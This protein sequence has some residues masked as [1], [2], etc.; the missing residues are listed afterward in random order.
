MSRMPSLKIADSPRR[1]SSPAVRASVRAQ[2]VDAADE[3]QIL[4]LG[5]VYEELMHLLHRHGN[6]GFLNVICMPARVLTLLCARC[7]DVRKIDLTLLRNVPFWVRVIEEA[8]RISGASAIRVES[9]D[10]CRDTWVMR[11]STAAL[12]ELKRS[13]E[14]R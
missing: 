6:A 3:P 13:V 11:D 14:G 2:A 10:S 8:C 1:S 12:A 5:H 4:G 7:E 9:C